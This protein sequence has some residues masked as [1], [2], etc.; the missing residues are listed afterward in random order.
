MASPLVDKGHSVFREWFRK[1]WQ[2]RGGGLYA[3]GFAATFII[4]EI[5]SLGEDLADLGSFLAGGFIA[6]II[7][8]VVDFLIHSFMNTVYA[9]IWPVWV[10]QWAP[11][12]GAI[13]L[14]LAYLGF[15]NYLKKPITDWLFDGEPDAVKEP[16]QS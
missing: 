15:A 7:A 2:V 1:V 12:W 5:G 8:F 3:C 10:V 9:L 14:G 6:T 11:P 4:L 16:E 13:G